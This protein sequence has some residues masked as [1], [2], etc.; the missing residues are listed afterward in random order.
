MERMQGW[1]N[2]PS[3]TVNCAAKVGRVNGDAK[4]PPSA[5]QMELP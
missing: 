1:G 5:S 4:T 3:V 2:P